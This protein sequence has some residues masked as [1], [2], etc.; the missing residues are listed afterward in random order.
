MMMSSCPLSD[1]VE[2]PP[3]QRRQDPQ[4]LT[5][6]HFLALPG[7]LKRSKKVA[8]GKE[9][10][11]VS[12]ERPHR[13]GFGDTAKTRTVHGVLTPRARVSAGLLFLRHP[14]TAYLFAI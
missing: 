7:S 14:Y 5:D 1:G 8:Q 10:V 11:R 13:P 3:P 2:L 9:S 6:L 4:Q 12:P